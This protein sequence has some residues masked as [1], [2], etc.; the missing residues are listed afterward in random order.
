MFHLKDIV[1]LICVVSSGAIGLSFLRAK[2]D[3]VIIGMITISLIRLGVLFFI[4]FFIVGE[5]VEYFLFM[6][7][8]LLLV[9]KEHRKKIEG[10]LVF[11]I[12][13]SMVKVSVAFWAVIETLPQNVIFKGFVGISFPIMCLLL[14]RLYPKISLKEGWIFCFDGSN[15]KEGEWMELKP[16]SL[17]IVAGTVTLL[18]TAI[19]P[20]ISIHS[21]HGLFAK[22]LLA[23][24]FFIGMIGVML[25]II[26][27]EQEREL[28]QVENLYRDEMKTFMNVV[29]SQ[30]H[31]Y[32]LHVQTVA[33]LIHQK[34]WDECCVYV[35]ALVKDTAEMNE[36]LPVQDPAIAALIGNYK[37]M[38]AQKNIELFIDI[39]NDLS[40]IVTNV[41]ETNKIIGN[42][43][44]NAIDELEH[45]ES[46]N[47]ELEL[48]I[49][50]RGEYCL[51]RVTNEIRD[52]ADFEKKQD[53]FF[54]YGYSTKKGHD[55]VGL[56]S[57]QSLMKRVGG[58]VYSWTEENVVHF[59]ASI[60][61]DYGKRL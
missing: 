14:F 9:W 32:N 20:Q 17:V 10:F 25:L 47:K 34:K 44:Q 55:G 43:L 2:N 5:I 41:Y 8:G 27:Y 3:T 30:R 19:F 57:I 31:D 37:I 52:P 22:A 51:I 36:I 38:A 13:M 4:P 28:F 61:E 33:S 50:K 11:G 59:I 26:E 46:K 45:I 60:P 7:L 48:S 1:Q 42:L 24:A 40:C 16:L 18:L 12:S 21:M 53:L 23:I 15:K 58:E 6:M 54:S 35:E 49:F 29:R 39:R 56:S